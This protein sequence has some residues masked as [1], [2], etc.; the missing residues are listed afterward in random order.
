MLAL[1]GISVNNVCFILT[2]QEY[3]EGVSIQRDSG[4]M[5]SVAVKHCRWM[6]ILSGLFAFGCGASEHGSMV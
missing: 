5:Q 6:H 3:A 2:L 1:F 4:E